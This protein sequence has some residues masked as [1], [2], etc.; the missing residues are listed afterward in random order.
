MAADDYRE[1]DYAYVRDVFPPGW[2]PDPLPSPKWHGMLQEN[3]YFPEDPIPSGQEGPTIYAGWVLEYD[4]FEGDYEGE[5]APARWGRLTFDRYLEAGAK[6][7]A[8]RLLETAII[9]ALDTAPEGPMGFDLQSAKPVWVGF[10]GGW[11]LE[12]LVISFCGG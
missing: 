6:K 1:T 3:G 9:R 4:L 11:Y 5:S 12:K 8:L 2:T 7:R 10:V